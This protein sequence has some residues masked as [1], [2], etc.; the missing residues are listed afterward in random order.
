MYFPWE[1]SENFTASLVASLGQDI[2]TSVS[3]WK[4]SPW[5][6]YIWSDTMVQIIEMVGKEAVSEFSTGFSD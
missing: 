1:L 4:S 6:Q 3:V 5:N 2:S